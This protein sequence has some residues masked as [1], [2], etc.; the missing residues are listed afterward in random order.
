[1]VLFQDYGL[2][3]AQRAPQY[4]LW[5]GIARTDAA[6]VRETVRALHRRCR[7]SVLQRFLPS[8]PHPLSGGMTASASRIRARVARETTRAGPDG[9]AVG[10][11]DAMTRERH[12]GRAPGDLRRTG[13]TVVFV[14]HSIE[15]AIFLADRVVVSRPPGPYRKRDENETS[16]P[17]ATCPA[18]SSNESGASSGR[19]LLPQANLAPQGG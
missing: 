5:T 11:L 10:A 13:L 18:P 7:G 9:R 12:A 6:E 3:M 2:F 1:M 16:A 17:G 4:R 19:K 14:T 8:F 15:E